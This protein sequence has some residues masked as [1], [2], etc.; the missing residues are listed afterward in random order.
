MVQK[1]IQPNAVT[2]VNPDFQMLAK[3]YRCR[4]DK[5]AS[6]GGLAKAIKLHFKPTVRPSS[7]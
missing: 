4:A 1:G 7:R 2:L 6:L 5:P 3:A